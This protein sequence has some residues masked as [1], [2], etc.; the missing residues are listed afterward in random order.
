LVA[1]VYPDPREPECDLEV[2]SSPPSIPHKAFAQIAVRGREK[3]MPKMR[4]LLRQEACGIGADAVI[5]FIDSSKVQLYWEAYPMWVTNR[6]PHA[7]PQKYDFSLIGVAIIYTKESPKAEG[8]GTPAVEKT[9]G[10]PKSTGPD[11]A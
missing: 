1:P 3:Q 10:G 8:G 6:A 7:V 9:G 11:P 2:F 5:T 4:R